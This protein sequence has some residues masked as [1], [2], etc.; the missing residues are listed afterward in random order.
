MGLGIQAKIR[1][2]AKL[3][4]RSGTEILT[5]VGGQWEGQ[6]VRV[7]IFCT[8]RHNILYYSLSRPLTTKMNRNKN[9]KK[10]KGIPL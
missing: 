9:G 1:S 2:T 10:F 8:V 4:W 5:C 7:G 3:W 6:R